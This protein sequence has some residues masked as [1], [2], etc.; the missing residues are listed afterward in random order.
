MRA[1][2]LAQKY[3]DYKA[4][5][6]RARSLEKYDY[7]LGHLSEF[8]GDAPVTIDRRK[9]LENGYLGG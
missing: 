8:L 9:P 6:L 5:T 3:R 4:K 1:I 7:M 2:A